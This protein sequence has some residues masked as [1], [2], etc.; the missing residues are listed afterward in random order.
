MLFGMAHLT[1]PRSE[2]AALVAAARAGELD[3]LL[4]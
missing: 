1:F 4:D 3:H 2:V